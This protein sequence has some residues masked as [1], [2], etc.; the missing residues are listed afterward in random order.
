MDKIEELHSQAM[1]FAELAYIA[2]LKNEVNEAFKLSE[3]A[4]EK[5]LTAATIALQ[6][7]IDE[8]SLSILHRSAASLAIECNK[9]RDAEKIVA[10]A[11]SGNP[12]DDIANE[13]R[14]LLE[15]V[16][17][18]RHLD[19]R[20]IILEPDEFQLSIGGLVVS[21]GMGL[22]DI[23]IEKFK[24]TKRLIFNTAGRL[25]GKPFNEIRKL[26]LQLYL[27]APRPASYAISFKVGHPKE[28]RFLPGIDSSATTVIEEL[29]DCLELFSKFEE[30]K[31]EKKFSDKQYY[32][33]FISIVNE[34]APD[35][36]NVKLVG[37]TAIK[38]GSE[39]KVALTRTKKD[40]EIKSTKQIDHHVSIKGKLMINKAII[41]DEDGKEYAVTIPEN[42]KS[43]VILEMIEHN[44]EIIGIKTKKGIIKL[45]HIKYSNDINSDNKTPKLP[46]SS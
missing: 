18:Y 37:F 26:N 17:F 6:K 3:Q 42:M 31:L 2:R 44:V 32:E 8:P 11:L 30:E 33:D 10:T 27:S 16:N 1:N 14:D 38:N 9:Y 7:N 22:M 5:E 39:K 29:T 13:L 23:L 41:I 28:Q 15:Q 20:G 25:I 40:I 4:F 36:E 24:Y 34:L 35:G 12:P 19:L 43:S 45:E 46:F 21:F